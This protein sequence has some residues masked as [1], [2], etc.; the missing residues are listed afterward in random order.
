MRSAWACPH[1]TGSC[2]FRCGRMNRRSPGPTWFLMSC[3]GVTTTRRPPTAAKMPATTL[4][5]IAI[6]GYWGRSRAYGDGDRAGYL[7]ALRR[8]FRA[9]VLTLAREHRA[10]ARIVEDALVLPMPVSLARREGRAEG[11]DIGGD[12]RVGR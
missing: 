7:Q 2:T 4:L 8:R 3:H 1:G 11:D 10:R 9:Q 6:A 5:A 12:R